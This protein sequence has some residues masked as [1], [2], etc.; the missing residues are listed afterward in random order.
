MKDK[1]EQSTSELADTLLSEKKTS[2]MK[3]EKGT[4]KK[5][6]R[7]LSEKK[8]LT[9]YVKKGTDKLA[10][11]KQNV[12]AMRREGLNQFEGQYT[13]NHGLFKLNIEFL[14]NNLS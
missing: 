14:R 8:S 9:K 6:D 10:F 13:G 12:H 4:D 2:T 1:Y 5:A 3:V 7:Q 11:K